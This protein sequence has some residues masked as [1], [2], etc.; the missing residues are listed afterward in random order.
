MTED[1]KGQ[2]IL[3]KAWD[4][5]KY[6]LEHNN[7]LIIKFVMHWLAFNWLYSEYTGDTDAQKIEDFYIRNSRRLDKYDPF[8]DPA[9]DIFLQKPVLSV[10][11]KS[12]ESDL[13]Y[14]NGIFDKVKKKDPKALLKTIY[15]V[16]CN[17]FHGG[18]N[19]NY[20]RDRQLVEA[21]SVIMEKYLLA[22]LK[23]E[24]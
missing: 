10:N 16:R 12:P 22:L 17:L 18:K 20:I 5:Y 9:V 11:P 8:S 23:W 21:A 14:A 1:E 19:P 2:L 7:D 3:G 4:W 6:G 13:K 15:R 24:Y